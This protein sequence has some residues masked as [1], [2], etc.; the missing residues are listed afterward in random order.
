MRLVNQT[1][2]RR[3]CSVAML[4]ISALLGS[5]V[6]GVGAEELKRAPAGPPPD[7]KVE[8]LTRHLDS[9]QLRL[10]ASDKQSQEERE[11][12]GQLQTQLATLK[13]SVTAAQ[14]ALEASQK[15][16]EQQSQEIAALRKQLDQLAGQAKSPTPAAARQELTGSWQVVSVVED[17]AAREADFDEVVFAGKTM[18][19]KYGAGRPA[20]SFEYKLDPAEEP[21]EITLLGGG[22]SP[23]LGIY[24]LRTNASG[25]KTE[26]VLELCVDQGKTLRPEQFKSAAGG[27]TALWQLKQTSSTTRA[28]ATK[29]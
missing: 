7:N 2:P 21:R 14:A 3:A 24:T 8:Q 15:M 20:R 12:R 19:I 25:G 23:V 13:Q 29:P 16:Q 28:D 5:L 22:R 26:T 4:S 1:F 27:Q 9:L 10:T 17:G 11:L 6:A 18:T